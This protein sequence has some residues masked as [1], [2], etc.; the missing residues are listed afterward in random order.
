MTYARRPRWA[1]KTLGAM[2]IRFGNFVP[3]MAQPEIANIVTMLDASAT[4]K[5]V[6]WLRKQWD[7]PLLIKGLQSP[8]DAR[9]ARDAG[10]SGIMIS[11]HG[12]RQLETAPA[13]VDCIAPMRDAIGDSLELICDGGIRRGTHVLKALAL[14]ANACS[15]GRGYLYALAAGGQ[16]GVERALTLLRSEIERD[17]ILMGARSIAEIDRSFLVERKR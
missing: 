2:P 11:N 6:E 17:M 8:D 7:G 3:H 14:G 15:I 1:L 9:H 5:D 4:W 12:G 16:P 10:A 13:P